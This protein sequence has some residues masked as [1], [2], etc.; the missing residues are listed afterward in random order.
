MQD[1]KIPDFILTIFAVCVPFLDWKS[2]CFKVAWWWVGCPWWNSCKWK[3]DNVIC[4]A[5]CE[6]KKVANKF[7][8]W[9]TQIG[10][11]VYFD[12]CIFNIKPI[13]V[14]TRRERDVWQNGDKEMRK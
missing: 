12:N 2:H 11:K 5:G 14:R 7:V 3:V 8:A 4:I 13:L 1:K 9:A 10:I 6:I